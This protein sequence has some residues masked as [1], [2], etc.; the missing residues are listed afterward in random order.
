MTQLE[1][2]Q[3]DYIEVLETDRALL[4][5]QIANLMLTLEIAQVALQH[6]MLTQDNEKRTFH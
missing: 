2:T 1:K 4:R 5:A 3:K 6:K